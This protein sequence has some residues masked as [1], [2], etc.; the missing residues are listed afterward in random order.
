MDPLTV[1]LIFSIYNL[2]LHPGLCVFFQSSSRPANCSKKRFSIPI[3]TSIFFCDV[4]C[5][6]AQFMVSF[7][8][9]ILRLSL[10][11]IW[12]IYYVKPFCVLYLCNL[13]NMMWFKFLVVIRVFISHSF[14]IRV[15]KLSWFHDALS[16]FTLMY[17][18]Q[19]LY[20][21]VWNC[22][23]N[24][25]SHWLLNPDFINKELKEKLCNYL[26]MFSLLCYLFVWRG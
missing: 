17:L 1:H 13:I 14:F 18:F 24:K 11:P 4:C 12:Y 5:Q 7:L 26:F 9:I 25:Q 22:S 20:I 19:L 8:C 21:G 2:A 23:V 10:D 6:H 15:W 3:S 16:F